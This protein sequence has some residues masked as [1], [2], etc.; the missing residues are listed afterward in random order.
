MTVKGLVKVKF[1]LARPTRLTVCH[2]LKFCFIMPGLNKITET[3]KRKKKTLQVVV[4]FIM[5]LFI[6]TS[7]NLTFQSGTTNQ[8]IS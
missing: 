8:P 3:T 7:G 5:Y 2:F 1:D 4:V 6:Y